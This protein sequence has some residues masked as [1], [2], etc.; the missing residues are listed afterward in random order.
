MLH[1]LYDVLLPEARTFKEENMMCL[2]LMRTTE[3]NGRYR[4]E[5]TGSPKKKIKELNRKWEAYC[6]QK[7]LRNDTSLVY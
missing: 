1:Y 5:F 4:V 7:G 2:A 3:K 6:E